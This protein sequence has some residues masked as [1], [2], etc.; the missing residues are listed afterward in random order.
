VYIYSQYEYHIGF[1]EKKHDHTDCVT[2]YCLAFPAVRN[3]D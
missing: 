1:L 2:N 3:S